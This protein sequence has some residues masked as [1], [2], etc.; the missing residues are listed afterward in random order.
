MSTESKSPAQLLAELDPRAPRL[1]DLL[2]RALE[3]DLGAGDLTTDAV[4]PEGVEA[5]G[6]FLAKES[7]VVAGLLVAQRVFELLDPS[8]RFQALVEEGALVNR[9]RLA[10]V[11][12]DARALLRGERVALNFLQRMSGIA[13]LTRRFAMRL[14]GTRARLRDTRKTTPGLRL[15][16]KYAVR[17]GGGSN[18][19]FGLYDGVLIKENHAQVAGSVGEVVR[20]AKARY[21][22]ERPVQVEVRDESE[23]REAL[24]AGADA[25]L[26]DNMTVEQVDTA[27]Q[28]VAGR[29]AVEASGGIRLE[30]VRAYAEC[31]VDFISIGALTHSAPAAD[32]SFDLQPAKGSQP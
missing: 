30:N 4:L 32:I 23:L 17:V 27:V 5:T 3:E 8:L 20:R 14:E 24:A 16:E 10:E 7:L 26:L 11:R 13:S 31:G 1:T 2:Q 28:L 12:G 6:T 25:L 21:R 22:G 15:L 9:G 18:H 29:V 19:R